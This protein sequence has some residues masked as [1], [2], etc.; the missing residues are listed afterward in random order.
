M[1][2]FD[3]LGIPRDG[4]IEFRFPKVAARRGC[5]RSRATLMTMPETAVNEDRELVFREN[6]I[7]APRQIAPMQPETAPGGMKRTAHEKFGLGIASLHAPHILAAPR[8][9]EMVHDLKYPASGAL[10]EPD[11]DGRC[12]S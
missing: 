3:L 12:R 8:R 2:R 6:D 11:R 7:G 10:R 4:S 5:G 1:K 9:V